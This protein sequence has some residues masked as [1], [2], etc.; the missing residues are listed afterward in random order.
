[1]RIDEQLKMICLKSDMSLSEMARRLNK[2]PQA[3]NQ[4]IKRG[5]FSIEELADLEDEIMKELPDRITEILT[6]AN[7]NGKLDENNVEVHFVYA[8]KKNPMIHRTRH[9]QIHDDGSMEDWPIGF[10]DEWEDALRTLTKEV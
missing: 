4:K 9:M 1:M 5:N 6:N 8:D 7:R 2:T 10:F 3:F